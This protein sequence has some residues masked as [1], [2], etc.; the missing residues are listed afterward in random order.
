VTGARHG[1]AIAFVLALAGGFASGTAAVSPPSYGVYSWPG[2]V[3]LSVGTLPVGVSAGYVRSTPY[4][5][6][7]PRACV[8]PYDIGQTVTLTAHPSSGYSF[9]SWNGPACAGQGNPCTFTI[10]EDTGVG[11]NF[12]PV[13][14]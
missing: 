7:C 1:A 3:L 14:R 12:S 11:A 13:G 5:V 9:S 10:A 2:A 8:R 6:D 4:Y